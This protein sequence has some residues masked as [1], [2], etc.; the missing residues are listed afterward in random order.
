MTQPSGL[1]YATESEK[2]DEARRMRDLFLPVLLPQAGEFAPRGHHRR[3]NMYE[4]DLYEVRVVE[5]TADLKE[6][7]CRKA[8]DR[9]IG[10]VREAL[11]DLDA[12]FVWRVPLELGI[13]IDPIVYS[14]PK[15]DHMEAMSDKRVTVTGARL[16]FKAFARYKIDR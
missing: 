6:G 4:P 9:L 16:Y 14:D 11:G 2:C 3:L 7:S 8:M 13:F 12:K 1:P 5:A 10:K 15:G